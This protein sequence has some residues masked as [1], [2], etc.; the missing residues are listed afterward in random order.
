MKFINSS[1]NAHDLILIDPYSLGSSAV[2]STFSEEGSGAKENSLASEDLLKGDGEE[3]V[4]LV[5]VKVGIGAKG[6]YGR[7]GTLEINKYF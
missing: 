5:L 2:E 7:L 6:A 4:N 3:Q 1:S